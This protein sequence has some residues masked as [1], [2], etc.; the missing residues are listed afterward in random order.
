MDRGRLLKSAI[1][2]CE[3][4]SI[5][6]MGEPEM[7][8]GLLEWLRY[9]VTIRNEN[10]NH[11]WWG[12]V[13]EVT[14]SLGGMAVGVDVETVRNRVCVAYTYADQTA[15]VRDTTAWAEDAASQAPYGIHE[16]R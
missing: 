4:A 12:D 13:A 1:G 14:V 8:W 15:A 9:S 10:G 7:L 16:E 6:V 5:S 2:G 3:E 11:V